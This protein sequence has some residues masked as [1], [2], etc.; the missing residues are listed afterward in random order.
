MAKIAFK[1]SPIHTTGELPAVGSKAPDFRLVTQNLEDK[2]L[3]D[4]AGKK[5]LLSTVPSL[6][7]GVCAASAKKFNEFAK[8]HPEI[9]FLVVSCDLPFAQKRFCSAEGVNNVLT[10]SMMRSKEF[11]E[12]YGL[13][14]KDGPLAGLSA[15]S[16]LILD[17]HNTILYTQLV[18]EITQEPDYDKAFQVLSKKD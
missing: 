3:K 17:S 2:T 8:K 10:L 11:A 4:F 18:P 1:G 14:I 5:K 12:H 15:R 9:V 7:T 16:V 13:L 6:D